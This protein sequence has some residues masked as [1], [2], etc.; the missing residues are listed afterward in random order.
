MYFFMNFFNLWIKYDKGHFTFPHQSEIQYLV[1]F[2]FISC[3]LVFQK[4]LFGVLERKM[5]PGLT[6]SA[7]CQICWVIRDF[8]VLFPDRDILCFAQERLIESSKIWSVKCNQIHF[9][10]IQITIII[11]II[12]GQLSG[13]KKLKYP[14]SV[15]KKPNWKQIYDY[16]LY[17]KRFLFVKRSHLKLL[18]NRVILIC[19]NTSNFLW[20]A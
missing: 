13:T 15:Q 17:H 4:C 16:Y 20:K 18:I 7:T 3:L 1:L 8:P 9:G 10:G 12:Y 19:M 2:Y 6:Y 14:G 11:R 5:H